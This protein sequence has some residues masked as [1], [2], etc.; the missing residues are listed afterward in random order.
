MS[1]YFNSHFIFPHLLHMPLGGKSQ[2]ILK[3]TLNWAMLCSRLDESPNYTQY[4]GTTSS[5]S[6]YPYTGRDM[7]SSS[8][9]FEVRVSP[10][11]N[12]SSNSQYR[13][14]P[15]RASP[16]M[17]RGYSPDTGFQTQDGFNKN[18]YSR[19]WNYTPSR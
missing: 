4:S 7:A 6:P 17:H 16:G 9:R 19:L 14:S 13:N 5:T 2:T 12:N 18:R 1:K 10:L 15:E 8:P 11:N 3:V